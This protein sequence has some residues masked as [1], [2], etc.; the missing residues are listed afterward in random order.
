[1]RICVE[2]DRPLNGRR[3]K[4]CSNACKQRNHYH[5]VKYQQNTY[6]SQTLRG[7]RRKLRLIRLHGGCCQQCSYQRNLAALQFHHR[8]SEEKRFQLDLRSLSNRRWATIAEEA[9]KCDL[10]CA[11]CHAELHHPELSID[12]VKQRLA[13]PVA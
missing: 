1:M 12:T 2:C 11:N 3:V 7:T 13:G 8:R 9:A 6:H 10:L 4:F 5:R